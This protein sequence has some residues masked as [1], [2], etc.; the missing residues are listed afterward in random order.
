MVK[1]SL[2][3]QISNGGVLGLIE[4]LG[5]LNK[6]ALYVGVPAEK[7]TRKG[8]GKINNAEL[9]YIHTHGIRAAQMRKEMHY[10]S[11]D[12]LAYKKVIERARKKG[13]WTELDNS[14]Y[15][16]ATG[17]YANLFRL[18]VL[19]HGSPLWHSPPRPVLLPALKA[20]QN[21]IAEEYKNVFKAALEGSDAA[22]HRAIV[23]TGLRAQNACRDWFLDPR[24]NWAPNAESTKRQK[25]SDRP[26]IDTGSLRT[27]IV[28]VVRDE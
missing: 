1:A 16:G 7:S 17:E 21:E 11:K 4:C 5:R 20:H 2:V 14:I 28:Y 27:S 25:K 19:K 8:E 10:W 23:R 3:K 9:L 12:P 6:Q 24:N 18:Y 13:N 22:L 26:L 15:P